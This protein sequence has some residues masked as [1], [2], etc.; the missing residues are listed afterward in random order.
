M[1]LI[2]TVSN[3]ANKSLKFIAH[4]RI[5]NVLTYKGFIIYYVLILH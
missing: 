3:A 5:S 4:F 2:G 1:P